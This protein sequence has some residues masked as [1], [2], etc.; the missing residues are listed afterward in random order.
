MCHPTKQHPKLSSEF[1]LRQQNSNSH[2]SVPQKHHLWIH[3]FLNNIDRICSNI[4]Y[5]CSSGALIRIWI[6]GLPD[7]RKGISYQVITF[8]VKPIRAT[9]K[10]I[11]G[12]VLICAIAFQVTVY[13]TLNGIFLSNNPSNL[14]INRQP[15]RLLSTFGAQ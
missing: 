1:N 6:K 2:V 5:V 14:F 12:L 8:Q 10:K 7:E 9:M 4:L 13:L 11:L 15:L 3:T